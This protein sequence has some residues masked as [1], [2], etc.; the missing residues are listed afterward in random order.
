[1]IVMIVNCHLVIKDFKNLNY[2]KYETRNKDRE[3]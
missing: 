2:S 1:M 3:H